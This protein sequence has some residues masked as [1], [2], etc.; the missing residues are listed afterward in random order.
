M[1]S[2]RS[3]LMRKA[4]HLATLCYLGAYQLLGYPGIVRPMAVWAVI[5]CVIETARLRSASLNR[6][7]TGLFGPLARP[8]EANRYSG[9][10]HT[11]L[12]AL[13]VFLMFGQHPT[14]VAASIYY[15]AL[16]DAAAAIVGKSLGR[17]RLPSSRKSAEGSLA[18]FAV[19]AAIGLGLGLPVPALIL[20][21][22]AA[23]VIELLPTTAWFNDNLWMPVTTAIVLRLCAI[24]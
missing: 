3:E 24:S 22:A 21:A 5:V 4:F 15:V 19:C 8:E 13:V 9:I 11:T 17:H 12:G 6:A 2:L 16:G 1:S 23:T 18:C 20:G 14:V 7:L 10:I